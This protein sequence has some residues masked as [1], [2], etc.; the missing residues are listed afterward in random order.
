MLRVSSRDPGNPPKHLHGTPQIIWDGFRAPGWGARKPFKTSSGPKSLW[1]VSRVP[2]RGTRETLPKRLRAAPDVVL[3]GFPDVG[4][5]DP[6][7]FPKRC[8]SAPAI[9]LRSF[10][11][12]PVQDLGNPSKRLERPKI[13]FGGFPNPGPGGAGKPSKTSSGHPRRHFG[14]F[15]ESRPSKTMSKRLRFCFGWFFPGP[16]PRDPGNSPKRVRIP[17]RFG[18]FSGARAGGPE[19]LPKRIREAPNV[20]FEGFPDPGPGDPGNPPKRIRGAA[21]I[22]LEGFA[23]PGA[24]CPRS[25]QHAKSRQQTSNSDRRIQQSRT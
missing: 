5:G 13:V 16:E 10:P 3:D 8:R 20:V 6:G 11:G 22:A 17:N 7:I 14:G 15:P 23:N 9:V 4:P 19:N 18:R 25:Q 12:P 1:R 24:G 2:G 21:T